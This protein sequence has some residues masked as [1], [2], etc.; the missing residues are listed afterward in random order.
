M[1]KNGIELTEKIEC[2]EIDT[3]H[4]YRITT[5]NILII[6]SF[7]ENMPINT[8]GSIIS[9]IPNKEVPVK[10]ILTMNAFENT[11]NFI[12]VDYIINKACANGYKLELE[13]FGEKEID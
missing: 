9:T 11:E 5:E 12:K 8:I 7:K 6:I 2:L 10:L 1:I 3:Y 13:V 4:F